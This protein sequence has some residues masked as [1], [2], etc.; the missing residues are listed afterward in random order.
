MTT[1]KNCLQDQLTPQWRFDIDPK[2]DAIALRAPA[3]SKE[4]S[5]SQAIVKLHQNSPGIII[6]CEIYYLLSLIRI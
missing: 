6:L 1:Q 5:C 2:L 4:N 3:A